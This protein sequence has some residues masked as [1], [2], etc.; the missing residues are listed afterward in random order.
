MSEPLVGYRCVAEH[1]PTSGDDKD[2]LTVHDGQWAY[3]PFDSKAD[4]HEWTPAGT[5][6]LAA[7]KRAQLRHAGERH[8]T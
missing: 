7:L 1:R 3:C 5:V 6:S 4:G 2:Q 8:G